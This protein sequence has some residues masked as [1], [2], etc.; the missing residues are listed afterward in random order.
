MKVELKSLIAK[1]NPICRKALEGGAERCV[2]QTNYDVEIEHIFRALLDLPESDL[3]LILRHYEVDVTAL[4]VELTRS[5]DGLKR[6]NT[7][8]PAFSPN[9]PRLLERA[10]SIS[11][12]RLG[13]ALVRSGALLLA[14][15]ED[16]GLR[17]TLRESL[18]SL[19]V[20]SPEVLER[21]LPELLRYSPEGEVRTASG[22]GS[23]SSAATSSV[24]GAR[25]ESPR[26][27]SAPHAGG[28]PDGALAQFTVDLT[29]QA[30]DGRIDPIRGR[31]TEIRQIVDILMRRRQNNPI[32][33][34]APGVG[35]TAVVEGFALAIAAGE[36]PPALETASVLT[37]DL[38]LLQA[39]AGIKG[40]FEHR[41]K[42]VIEEVKTSPNPI[43][44]FID[45]AHTIIGAG[46]PEGQGDAANLLKPALARGE[47]RTIA[48]TTWS[49]YKRYIEKDPALA[50]RFQVI[51]VEEPDEETAVSMIQG[52]ISQLEGHHGV[53]ILEGAVRDAVELSHRHISGRQLPDKAVSVLDTACARVAIGQASPPGPVA[54]AHRRTEQLELELRILEREALSG[55]DQEDRRRQ[56]E[57]SVTKA[58]QRSAELEDQWK[59]E[60]DLVREVLAVRKQ[61][62]GGGF[63]DPL[64]GREKL[65]SLEATLEELQGEEP[66]VPLQV[67]SRVVASVISDWT[68][69]PVGKMVKDEARTVLTLKSRLEGRIIGQS[70]PLEMICRRIGTSSAQLEDP[71]KPTGVFLLVGPSGVGKTETA[72]TLSDFLYGGERNVITVNMSEYQEAHT[73]SSLKGAP[74]GYVGFGRGGVLTEAVRRRPYSLVLL[75]EIEKAHPDVMEL[76]YQVFDRGMMEDGEGQ[77]IDFKHTLILLTSNIGTEAITR[78]CM[79]GERPDPE[80]LV[81]LVRPQLLKHFPP[82]FLG[83]LV[84]IPYYVL[85]DSEIREIV[86]LRLSRIQRRFWERHKAE[87][88]YDPAVVDLIAARCTE[89]DSGARNIDHIIS[90]TML[91]DLSTHIL[92]HM[93]R[94]APIASIHVW[95]G[96]EGGFE[97]SIATHAPP[98][99]A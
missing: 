82:A 48:A 13:D 72:L 46:G 26:P 40:E 58:R 29:Q 79:N 28:R 19:S 63:E 80:T 78:A 90:G 52:V 60:L 74:P 43:I 94:D 98:V 16:I 22:G 7:R 59:S 25:F 34:G 4:E 45:E 5:I 41:L 50:R 10:W 73:V 71:E 8:T 12:L 21:D 44:L 53:R 42:S 95:V 75:D 85:G 20:I 84:V 61:L 99:P 92:D 18:P 69:I 70:E 88:T 62:E 55:T 32:L 38:G 66:L 39:G 31:D 64:E 87:L 51:K 56:L 15:L 36:V 81:E 11:S 9:V 89:V 6:G 47:L 67:D 23:P 65:F 37:L 77:L 17:G 97:Y 86:E 33:T 54:D 49:E 57:R 3:L 14:A 27:A 1:L 2:R 35:K 24:G 83:R 76:F 93:A 96:E 91:P 68:G 30:R